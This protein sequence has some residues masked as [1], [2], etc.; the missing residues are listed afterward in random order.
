VIYLLIAVVFPPGGSGGKIVHILGKTIQKHAHKVEGK[1]YKTRK[2]HE[3]FIT[4]SKRHKAHSNETMRQ[5]EI[6][7]G[8]PHTN[9]ITV[10]L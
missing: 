9:Y 8:N 7:Y 6:L 4:K 1:P 5:L 2:H 3:T 10:N